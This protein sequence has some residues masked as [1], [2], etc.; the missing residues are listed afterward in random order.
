MTGYVE[1]LTDPSYV[2][3]TRSHISTHWQLRRAELH[4]RRVRLDQVL[5]VESYTRVSLMV[6]E[7]CE[8]NSHWNACRSLASWLREFKIPALQGIDTRRLTK[9]LREKGSM[10]A[11]VIFFQG[12]LIHM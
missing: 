2:S 11:K 4:Q 6:G 1:S 9:V 3:T 7:Y 12:D 8:Q 10:L 5:R